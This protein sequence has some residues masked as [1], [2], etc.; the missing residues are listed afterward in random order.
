LESWVMCYD[1]QDY[2][3]SLGVDPLLES[4]DLVEP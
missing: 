3:G 2:N 1:R 4:P